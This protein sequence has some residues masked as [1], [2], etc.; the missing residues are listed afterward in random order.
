MRPWV[1]AECRKITSIPIFSADSKRMA[2]AA[3]IN[4]KS[5]AVIVDGQAGAECDEFDGARLDRRK[6]RSDEEGPRD[7]GWWTRKAVSLDRERW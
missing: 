5:S 6:W 7:D 4:E 3:K 2:Y 1:S